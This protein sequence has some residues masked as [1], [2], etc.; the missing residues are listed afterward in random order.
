M[1]EIDWE[2]AR[3]LTNT[4]VN[5]LKNR[6][7]QVI[8]DNPHLLQAFGDYMDVNHKTVDPILEQK[9]EHNMMWMLHL[10][11]MK[12]VNALIAKLGSHRKELN[13]LTDIM[14]LIAQ[15]VDLALLPNE[16]REI[17]QSWASSYKEFLRK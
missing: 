12:R 8:S 3:K 4:Y 6:A 14:K 5:D 16:I 17:V 15:T 11:F 9:W 13:E 7:N 2:K 1:T 10:E